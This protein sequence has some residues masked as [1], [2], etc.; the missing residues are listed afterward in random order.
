M[1][2]ISAAANQTYLLY[3]DNWSR[4]GISFNMAWDNQPT[5]LIDC[6]LEKKP[7]ICTPEIGHRSATIAHL[8]NLS[9]RLGRDIKWDPKTE[10]I[11]GDDEASKMLVRPM[12]A[13]WSDVL[14]APG[15]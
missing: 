3:V 12:R 15:A 2:Y 1:Q 4:N 7:T 9:L 14:H 8:G 5:N 6:I 10:T 13:K 11:T